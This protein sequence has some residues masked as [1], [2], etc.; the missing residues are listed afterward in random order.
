MFS[1]Y[2]RPTEKKESM[3]LLVLADC[4]SQMEPV[5]HQQPLIQEVSHPGVTKEAP[6]MGVC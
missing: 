6:G 4:E 2:L 5:C 3:G 1:C